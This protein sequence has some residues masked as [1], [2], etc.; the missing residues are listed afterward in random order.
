MK[1][2]LKQLNSESEAFGN[3]PAKKM[4]TYRIDDETKKIADLVV[5]TRSLIN[6]NRPESYTKL[7]RNLI[8]EEWL[9]LKNDIHFHQMLKDT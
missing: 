1:E 7:I 5:V 8:K 4:S 2:A 9:R 6:G 3:K